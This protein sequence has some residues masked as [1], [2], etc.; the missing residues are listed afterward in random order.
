MVVEALGQMGHETHVVTSLPWY[1][2]HAVADGWQGSPW[3]TGRHEHGTITRL[4]PFPTDKTSLTARS[5]G[6]LGFSAMAA[7]AAVAARGPFDAVLTLSPPLTLAVAGWLAAERHRCPLIVDIQDV[8]P[9]VAIQVGAV[10]SPP[11]TDLFRHLERFCYG[12]AAAV[13]A[14][15]NDLA[16]NVGA[17]VARMRRPPRVEV[18]PNPVDTAAVTPASRDTPYRSELGLGDATV[19]MYAGNLGHSQSLDLVVEVARRHADRSDIAYLVNGGGVMADHMARAAADLPNL[20]VVGYQPAER[21]PEVLATADV[22]LVLLKTGLGASSVPSKAFSALA[23]GRPLIAAI[24]PGTEVAKVV[25]EAGA[26]LA[27]LPDDPDAFVAAVEQLA[28]DPDTCLSMGESG[29]SW[30]SQR[31]SPAVVAAAFAALAE[32]L[33]AR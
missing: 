8:F 23:A 1:E 25:T 2:H 29:R 30:I 22:H 20:T 16:D 6:Y 18:I 33:G 24:D 19:F 10:T 9:D 13:R 11:P 15:S 5:L 28:D 21:V 31:R 7:G 26:G 12:R 3:R 17:K 14:L 32:D 27:V 4:H